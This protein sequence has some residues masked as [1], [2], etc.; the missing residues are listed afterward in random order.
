MTELQRT[1]L[2]VHAC[3]P[4]PLC[5]ANARCLQGLGAPYAEFLAS[6]LVQRLGCPVP[7]AQEYVA[8]CKSGDKFMDAFKAILAQRKGAK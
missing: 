2:L 1:L 5:G 6:F 7:L 3:R 8:R 4:A